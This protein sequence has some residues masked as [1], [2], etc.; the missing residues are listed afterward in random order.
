VARRGTARHR[1]NGLPPAAPLPPPHPIP[2]A[3]RHVS[4]G[5][6]NRPG[7]S[8]G[9]DEPERPHGCCQPTQLPPARWGR[10]RGPQSWWPG[11]AGCSGLR[12]RRAKSLRPHR[13]PDTPGEPQPRFWGA[14]GFRAASPGHPAQ[15]AGSAVTPARAG[16]SR[17]AEPG[18]GAAGSAAHPCARSRHRGRPGSCADARRTGKWPDLGLE[19]GGLRRGTAQG[20][21]CL[22][23]SAGLR[24]ATPGSARCCKSR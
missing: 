9:L 18:A 11:W 7:A 2:A 13:H 4:A 8:H 17:A 3:P 10:Q 24:V 12:G 16:A 5:G 19:R 15:S 23:P 22:N 20:K 1:P 21:R 14:P 6:K